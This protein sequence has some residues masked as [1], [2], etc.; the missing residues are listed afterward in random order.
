MD[1]RFPWQHAFDWAYRASHADAFGYAEWYV[2]NYPD[3]DYPH[4]L[5]YPEFERECEA[6]S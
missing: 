2:A 6:H 3:G 1:T 4:T 5:A